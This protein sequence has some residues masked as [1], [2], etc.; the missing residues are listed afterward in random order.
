MKDNVKDFL[1]YGIEQEI[2]RKQIFSMDFVVLICSLMSIILNDKNFAWNVVCSLPVV[3]CII[4]TFPKKEEKARVFL[5]Y[6][7]WSVSLTMCF[8]LLATRIAMMCISSDR[9]LLFIFVIILIY[10][11]VGGLYTGLIL[12]LQKKGAYSTAK[13]AN[14]RFSF[15]FTGIAGILCSRAFLSKLDYNTLLYMGSVCFYLTSFLSMIGWFNL[16]KYFLIKKYWHQLG[17]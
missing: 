15:A 12:H 5:I 2:P 6:G 14:I 17:V 13:K 3:I 11:L 16:I 10:I 1:L 4:F 7:I 8:G 9:Y